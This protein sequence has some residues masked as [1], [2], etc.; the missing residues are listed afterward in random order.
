MT[1]PKYFT[2]V[3]HGYSE[4]N[5]IQKKVRNK[6]VIE[7]PSEFFDR[8]DSTMRLTHKGVT[9]AEAAGDWLQS[10]HPAFDRFYV[11]PHSRT[12]ETAHNMHLGGEWRVDD[13]FRDRDWGKLHSINEDGS[14][15]LTKEMELAQKKSAWYWKPPGGESLSTGVR[16]R[17]TDIMATL[18]R[19]GK[20]ENVVGV[21][22][23]EFLRVVQFVIEKM[24]PIQREAINRD[25]NYAM[26]N[27]MI[28]QYSTVNPHTG[29]VS[30]HYEWR[31]AICPWDES[32]SWDDGEWVHFSSP[33]YSDDELLSLYESHAPI[34]DTQALNV[35]DRSDFTGE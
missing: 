15:S 6:D 2:L 13:R 4:A 5:F 33:K 16:L 11:S 25:P 18:Y 10:N 31:R 26:Q 9:Q 12:L 8:H 14:S 28:L 30:E 3:R 17:V 1:L 32:L 27:A 21:A 29:D 19:Q 22:H 35:I 20:A 34:F 7:I 24:T 23:G